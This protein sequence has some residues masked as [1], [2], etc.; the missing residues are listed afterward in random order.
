M[1]HRVH[2]HTLRAMFQHQDHLISYLHFCANFIVQ[3]SL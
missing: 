1:K 2:V 3:P